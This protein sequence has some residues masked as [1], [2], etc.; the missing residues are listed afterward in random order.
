MPHQGDVGWGESAGLVDGFADGA[1][2]RQGFGGEG[3][4]VSGCFL[5]RRRFASLT[6]V[7][8]SGGGEMR[9]N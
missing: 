4:A 1:L 6:Q 2:K 9:N 7:V 5:P 8:E 3:A